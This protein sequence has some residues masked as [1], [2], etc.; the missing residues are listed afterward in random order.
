MYDLVSYMYSFMLAL[1]THVNPLYLEKKK[2]DCS[3]S[4]IVWQITALS[5]VLTVSH[6]YLVATGSLKMRGA[7]LECL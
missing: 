6:F 3:Q 1:A 5:V 7:D 4:L 2:T